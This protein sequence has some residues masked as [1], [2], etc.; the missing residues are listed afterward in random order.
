MIAFSV[1]GGQSLSPQGSEF[2]RCPD[3]GSLGRMGR[4]G[5]Q[6][7]TTSGAPSSGRG[8][9]VR[10]EFDHPLAREAAVDT[11][12][13]RARYEAEVGARAR[14]RPPRQPNEQTSVWTSNTRLQDDLSR[15]PGSANR[16]PRRRMISAADLACGRFCRRQLR[17]QH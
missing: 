4:T 17:L 3:Q 7:G 13:G 5:L 11:G 10:F 2:Y 6:E 16:L 1:L 9:P 14:A 15:D 12:R 8:R